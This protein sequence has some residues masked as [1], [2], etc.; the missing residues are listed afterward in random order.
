MPK[1]G[2]IALLKTDKSLLELGAQLEAR[3][4]ELENNLASKLASGNQPRPTSRS[5]QKELLELEVKGNA[6]W[7]SVAI[8]SARV[9]SRHLVLG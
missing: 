9:G 4:Q 7:N 8:G 6:L 1:Q 3:K 2:A 5:N